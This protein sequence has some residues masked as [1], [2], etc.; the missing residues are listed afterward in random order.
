M[1]TATL[2]GESVELTITVSTTQRWSE[3]CNDKAGKK[4]ELGWLRLLILQTLL[5]IQ[6]AARHTEGRQATLPFSKSNG[7]RVPC[8]AHCCPYS[9]PLQRRL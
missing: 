2:T 4:Q 7:L 6:A 3:T 9:F 5:N 1:Q 8:Y